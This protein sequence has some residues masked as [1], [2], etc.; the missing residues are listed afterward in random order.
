MLTT[1]FEEARAGWRP[2][3]RYEKVTPRTGACPVALGSVSGVASA[4]HL[5]LPFPFE[6]LPWHADQ[7]NPLVSLPFF[8]CIAC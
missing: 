5:Q 1:G 2:A 8:A 3:P 7:A 6:N 4:L